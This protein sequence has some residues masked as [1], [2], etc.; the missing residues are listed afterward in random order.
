MKLFTI[1]LRYCWG[2]FLAYAH[3]FAPKPL[4]RWIGTA[5]HKRIDKLA[6]VTTEAEKA[7]LLQ[8]KGEGFTAVKER[9]YK[10]YEV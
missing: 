6:S 3:Y 4:K 7:Q 5:E 8:A 2:V 9:L 10:K 1:Y